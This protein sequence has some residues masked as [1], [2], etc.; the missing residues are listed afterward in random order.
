MNVQEYT[1]TSSTGWCTIRNER[2]ND[3]PVSTTIA[4]EWWWL[5]D[6]VAIYHRS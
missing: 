3:V 6:H 2:K 4:Y 1:E 5:N